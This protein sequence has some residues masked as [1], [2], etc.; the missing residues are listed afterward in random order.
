MSKHY[1]ERELG[2]ISV[3]NFGADKTGATNTTVHIQAAID[4]AFSNG[5]GIVYLPPGTY[6]VRGLIL[7]TGVILRGAGSVRWT[8]TTIRFSSTGTEDFMIGC[9]TL[10]PVYNAG[11]ENIVFDGEGVASIGIKL[12]KMGR[13]SFLKNVS[14][15]ESDICISMN[16]CAS[17]VLENIICT[18][19]RYG[20]QMDGGISGTAS[21]ESITFINLFIGSCTSDA[22]H[23]LG[24][25]FGI[26]FIGGI[27]RS[28][29]G[30]GLSL[31]GDFIYGVTT[32]SQ[33][34]YENG[35]TAEINSQI[36][37]NSNRYSSLNIIG[38]LIY[39]NPSGYGIYFKG[40][41][42]N[43]SGTSFIR[44]NFLDD[45][46]PISHVTVIGGRFTSIGESTDG[47]TSGEQFDII[48]SLRPEN[49]RGGQ[50]YYDSI[51]GKPIWY[52]GTNW[53]DS[54]GTVV[55]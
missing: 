37:V 15:I 28:N 44:S 50:Q 8:S 55:L 7:K 26:I 32:I 30:N 48:A 5:G 18:H 25:T 4:K 41:S 36:R 51:L 31:N 35:S 54:S 47:L 11:L 2:F 17:V 22:V 12:N 23:V 53:T 49:P 20:I 52:N 3:M 38:G 10:N 39:A 43:V 27:I 1:T 6:S 9:D 29:K 14:S 34:L 16:S 45:I 21:N 24:Y 42:L 40:N 19:G 13:G 46:L 33:S